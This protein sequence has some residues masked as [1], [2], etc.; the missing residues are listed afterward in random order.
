[1]QLCTKKYN[2][3]VLRTR[4]NNTTSQRKEICHLRKRGPC[5]SLFQPPRCRFKLCI[6]RL[7]L[8]Q[9]T[10]SRP[11]GDGT[12]VFREAAEEEFETRRCMG[13]GS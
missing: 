6:E 1:M 7:D 8:V 11:R 4:T 10:A 9:K 3:G 13:T 2:I 12:D 5:A